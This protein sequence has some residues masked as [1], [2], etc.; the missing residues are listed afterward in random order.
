MYSQYCDPTISLP[1][2]VPL[3][4]PTVFQIMT[5]QFLEQLPPDLRLRE[6]LEDHP[7]PPCPLVGLEHVTEFTHSQAERPYYHCS[8]PGCYNDQVR[9]GLETCY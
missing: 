6:Y 2:P 9:R 4:V 1:C 8:L 7:P 3:S 5:D